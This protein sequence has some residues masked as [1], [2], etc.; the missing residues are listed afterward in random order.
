MLLKPGVRISGI[1]PE[2]LLAVIAMDGIFSQ[3]A[4]SMVITAVIDGSHSRGS[5]HYAGMAF[6]VRTRDLPINEV[7]EVAS[8][9]RAALGADFDVVVET[10]HL[11]VEYQPKEAYTR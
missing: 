11:H 1:R 6:D 2:L 5:L 3:R 9:A 4:K 10:D 8:L 7:D